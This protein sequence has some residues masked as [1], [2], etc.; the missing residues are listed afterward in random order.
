MISFLLSRSIMYNS[1]PPNVFYIRIEQSLYV[2]IIYLTWADLGSIKDERNVEIAVTRTVSLSFNN[3]YVWNIWAD[4]G[5]LWIDKFTYCSYICFIVPS[6][7]STSRDIVSYCLIITTDA[8]THNADVVGGKWRWLITPLYRQKQFIK[9]SI[10]HIN[11][12]SHCYHNG[13][14]YSCI[15]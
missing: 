3:K 11:V 9:F 7:V 14:D 2:D 10:Q 1:F 15:D 4:F 13:K 12:Y 8:P 5:I 6:L